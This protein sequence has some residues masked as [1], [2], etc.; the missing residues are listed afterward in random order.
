[1]ANFSYKQTTNIVLKAC[2]I[3]DTDNGTITVDDEEKSINTLLSDFNGAFVEL[4]LKTKNE[5]ELSEPE[6]PAADAEEE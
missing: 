1:M 4:N 5:V 3:L 6:P 2:G